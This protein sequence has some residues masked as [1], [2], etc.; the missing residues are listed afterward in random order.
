MVSGIIRN[1]MSSYIAWVM[2]T[3]EPL[4]LA[5]DSTVGAELGPLAEHQRRQRRNP[6]II[7][8]GITDQAYG[9]GTLARSLRRD[10]WIVYTITM[11]KQGLAGLREGAAA[12]AREVERVKRE[13][14]ATQVDLVGHSQGGL[15]IR[16]YAKFLDGAANIGRAVS[17]ATPHNGVSGPYQPIADVV[18]AVGLDDVVS[19]GVVELLHDSP[20]IRMLNSGDP[21][22]GDIAW[23]SIYSLDADGIVF[24]AN[25]PVLE[26]AHNVALTKVERSYGRVGRGPHHIDINHTS[27]EAYAALREALLMAAPSRDA[28]RGAAALS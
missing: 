2:R 22:P 21:T 25:S 28:T 12:L 27:V 1:A 5:P 15:M 9:S 4:A 16:W 6:V 23:T 10:G 17:L 13:T 24:P 3:I 11:P 19:T 18:R 20:E 26:G 14:G 7:V 8:H